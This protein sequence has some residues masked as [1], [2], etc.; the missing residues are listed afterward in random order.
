M[1]IAG[2]VCVNVGELSNGFSLNTPESRI[3]DEGTE[4]AVS[5]TSESTEVHVFDGSVI[6]IPE[7]A[8]A[9]NKTSDFTDRIEAGEARS[10]LRSEP[11]KPQRIPFGQRQFVRRLEDA[12]KDTGGKALFVYDGFENLAGRVRR[13]RSGF[14]WSGG[15]QAGG[16]G[17]GKLGEIIDCPDDVVF[18][19]ERSQ[20]RMMLLEQGTDIRRDLEQPLNLIAREDIYVGVL[21]A[22]QTTTSET[23]GLSLQISLEPD[24]AGRRRRLHQVVSFGVATD[25]FP[26][27]RSANRITKTASKLDDNQTVFC[28]LK[29]NVG[30]DATTPSLRVYRSHEIIDKA[31]PSAWTVTGKPGSL[32]YSPSSI[33]ITA[34]ENTAWQI[35]E[36]KIGKTWQSIQTG[37]E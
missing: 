26:Y 4:Y 12:V 24:L 10:Y 15:W 13:G 3:I 8:G 14:G 22:R 37:I 30:E 28:V 16:R 33:R 20:R 19:L 9:E 1:L 25:G 2:D 5:L 29:L 32:A 31:E 35:D 17:R 11:S 27:I 21:F 23:D 18:G 6:W 36:L 34:G 7:N